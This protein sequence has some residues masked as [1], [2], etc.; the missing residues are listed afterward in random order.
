MLIATTMAGVIMAIAGLLRVGTYVRLIPHPVVV[1]FTAGIG[2]TIFVSQLH[3][4][5]GLRVTGEPAAFLPKLAVLWSVAGTF[6]TGA[7]FIAVASVVAIVLLRRFAPRVPSL[8]VAVAGAAVF[9]WVLELNVETIGT[10]FG[11]IPHG[12]PMPALP[13]ISWA[14]LVQLLPT[15]LSFALLGS[16]ESLLS[17]VVADGMTGRRHRSNSELCAPAHARLYRACCIQW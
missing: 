17:A 8:L 15:A 5:L 11:G 16:I 7:I 2:V 4:L 1:G 3:D 12:L 6:S 10:R 9:T 13:D 14:R